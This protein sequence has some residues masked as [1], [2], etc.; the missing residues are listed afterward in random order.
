MSRQSRADRRPTRVV[1]LHRLD[2][3]QMD[4]VQFLEFR[5]RLLSFWLQSETRFFQNSPLVTQQKVCS[6][7]WWSDLL[8]GDEEGRPSSLQRHTDPGFHLKR[9]CSGCW[10]V[11]PSG[12]PA[13]QKSHLDPGF[14]TGPGPKNTYHPN[15]SWSWSRISSTFITKQPDFLALLDVL[16]FVFFLSFSVQ[17]KV[18]V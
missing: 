10:E 13:Q 3:Q 6:A 18:F 17:M 16:R 7:G 14:C 4:L 12:F 9:A 2:Q 5:L 11:Q 1:L 8:A 15:L